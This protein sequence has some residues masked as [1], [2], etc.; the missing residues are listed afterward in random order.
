MN[1][2]EFLYN[3]RNGVCGLESVNNITPKGESTIVGLIKDNFDEIPRERKYE[4][5][6]RPTLLGRAAGKGALSH[7]GLEDFKNKKIGLFFGISVGNIGEKTYQDSIIHANSNH[8]K[9]IPIPFAHSANYHSITSAI[10]HFLGVNGITKT[11]TTGC[12]SSLEAIQD[13]MVYLKS[14]VID[15]AI[16]GGSDSPVGKVADR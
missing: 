5:L 13:A 11:I 15:I 8:Y 14:G 3:L 4:R 6:S 1:I 2:E 7:S 16:V 9:S 12:T 10:G